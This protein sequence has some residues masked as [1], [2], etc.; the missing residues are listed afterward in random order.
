MKFDLRNLSLKTLT[1][2]AFGLL[3][4]VSLTHYF[5]AKSIRTGISEKIIALELSSELHNNIYLVVSLVN[6]I[7][8]TNEAEAK[9]TLKSVL[10]RH[11]NQLSSLT[12]GSSSSNDLKALKDRSLAAMKK[13][14][15]H[16][17]P[18]KANIS[19]FLDG[20]IQL[21]SVYLASPYGL[22][23]ETPEIALKLINTN[24]DTYI[25]SLDD[26]N[27]IIGEELNMQQMRLNRVSFSFLLVELVLFLAFVLSIFK[28]FISP[29]DKL[30]MDTHS[31][32]DGLEIQTEAQRFDNEL[33]AI[34][35]GFDKLVH[36]LSGI[37]R[38]VK[39]IGS[40]N[41]EATLE[42][43][44]GVINED[45][46]EGALI[47]MRDQMKLVQK[48]EADRKWATEGLAQFVEILRST[49]TDVHEL[50]DK[51][52]SKLV[53]YTNSNQGGIYLFN[54]NEENPAL[55]LISLYAFSNKKYEQ[56]T[57]RLGEGVVGQTYL[58]R[59]TT[60]L[61]EIPDNYINIVSGLGGANP[62]A[63]L[64]VPLMVNDDIYGILEIAS[65]NEYSQHEIDFIE[66][67]GESI[68]STIS[69]VKVNQRTK[70]LLEESQ[71]LTEQMQSQEEEMRQ[72]ME[73]LTATQ[74]EMARTEKE[75]LAQQSAI[76]E[77]I[78][79]A[80]YD[81]M[82][83]ITY[84]NNEYNKQIGY[85]KEQLQGLNIRSLL[86]QSVSDNYN[87]FL[88]KQAS[89]G[90]VKTY[91]MFNSISVEG[92]KKLVE[93]SVK[94]DKLKFS[95]ED[96]NDLEKTLRQQLAA[97]DITQIKLED[98]IKSFQNKAKTLLTATNILI[99]DTDLEVSGANNA[100]ADRFKKDKSEL[101]GTTVYGL[102]PD[103]KAEPGKQVLKTLNDETFEVYVLVTTNDRE[104][105]YFVHWS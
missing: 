4:L 6:R 93:L 103:F 88:D 79:I 80:E 12:F 1:S 83:G 40:G 89:T 100:A 59:K 78:G 77:N 73:E 95:D 27:K 87:G 20:G 56:K 37:T 13:A 76:D 101:I 105:E 36:N 7:H 5:S 68:A 31:L 92:D 17:W 97:L 24:S 104:N 11:Q 69:G 51:I 43:T 90:I 75:K 16:W 9:T 22:I 49:D 35:K 21:D 41:L 102:F 91:S 84:S 82:G 10:N 50:G 3:A 99:L 70:V 32:A 64:I 86:G 65:F 46:L 98:Q 52:I 30:G 61:L 57:I 2:L 15:S 8:S 72:N 62:K 28:Y 67:L 44:E 25:A 53:E 55:E 96:V 81:A 23:G 71:Q 48:E 29:I 85:T 58:E 39:E 26:L 47:S 74:E 34:E 60:Y 19:I 18:L 66:K 14:D 54:D 63:I 38:F 45:S 94:S 42:R 33:G